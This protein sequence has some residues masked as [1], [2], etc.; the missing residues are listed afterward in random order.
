MKSEL[1]WKSFCLFKVENLL[2]KN[3]KILANFQWILFSQLSEVHITFFISL[4]KT[5]SKFRFDFD[6][7]CH[8]LNTFAKEFFTLKIVLLSMLNSSTHPN[9]LSRFHNLLLCGI[10]C[11]AQVGQQILATSCQIFKKAKGLI[12]SKTDVEGKV[13]LFSSDM[14]W[15]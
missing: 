12:S 15:S 1:C 6:L 8:F 7:F 14:I 3:T 11:L 10:T 9:C 4:R 2:C 13:T 5:L